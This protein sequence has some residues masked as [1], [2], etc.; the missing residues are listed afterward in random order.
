M[1]LLQL[2]RLSL[3]T[4]ANSTRDLSAQ[5]QLKSAFFDVAFEVES[6]GVRFLCSSHALYSVFAPF[7][8]AVFQELVPLVQQHFKLQL[9][10]WS[11][12]MLPLSELVALQEIGRIATPQQLQ[13]ID[14][15]MRRLEN[16]G[17]DPVAIQEALQ[18]SASV[19]ISPVVTPASAVAAAPVKAVTTAPA[20]A[21]TTA[22]AVVTVSSESVT[23]EADSL[24]QNI[25]SS[26]IV[27][28]PEVIT[29]N[30]AN[31]DDTSDAAMVVAVD[32]PSERAA[33]SQAPVPAVDADAATKAEV[34]T[35]AESAVSLEAAAADED[36]VTVADTV[37][38]LAQDHI[39][40]KA[41][42]LETSSSEPIEP[43]RIETEQT[44][45]REESARQQNLHK[46]LVSIGSACSV[47]G[48]SV[49]VHSAFVPSVYDRST[50][51]LGALA[52]DQL[53][54]LDPQCLIAP[55]F[56]CSLVAGFVEQTLN[57][58]AFAGELELESSAGAYEYMACPYSSFIVLGQFMVESS[59]RWGR[60]LKFSP[61][62]ESFTAE[63]L[64]LS[65]QQ[66]NST[67]LGQGQI[68]AHFASESGHILRA[69]NAEAVGVGMAL[70][71]TRFPTR[72]VMHDA[73][74]QSRL[75]AFASLEQ[76]GYITLAL[77]F[78][79]EQDDQSSVKR[80]SVLVSNRASA[81]ASAS[82]CLLHNS[83]FL[84]AAT[85]ALSPEDLY[86]VPSAYTHYYAEPQAVTFE[87]GT[88]QGYT[89][90]AGTVVPFENREQLIA[91]SV[92]AAVI[93]VAERQ[94][95]YQRVAPASASV[96]SV[97]E[98]EAI[99]AR[100]EAEALAYIGVD[101]QDA[102]LQ[103]VM[104][105]S[106]QSHKI[107]DTTS[108]DAV[109]SAVV[110]EQTARA[111]Q[112]AKPD[113]STS[114]SK[115]DSMILGFM[116]QE[117]Q[118]V[119]QAKTTEEEPSVPNASFIGA[120][121]A[122]A[123][124][125]AVPVY[126]NSN[127]P[128][129]NV[130]FAG[131]FRLAQESLFLA[132]KDYANASLSERDNH[133]WKKDF[134]NEEQTSHTV[135]ELIYQS[136]VIIKP[137]GL[138]ARSLKTLVSAMSHLKPDNTVGVM[139]DRVEPARS[140]S[141]ES[142]QNKEFSSE[143]FGV[144]S[145]EDRATVDAHASSVVKEPPVSAPALSTQPNIP[146]TVADSGPVAET[147][148]PVETGLV[149]DNAV[150]AQAS[151]A[152]PV[153][154]SA[155]SDGVEV[156]QDQKQVST[157]VQVADAQRSDE[158]MP[159]TSAVAHSAAEVQHE[160][161][162]P[163]AVKQTDV[164]AVAATTEP[165][166]NDALQ[167]CCSE[168]VADAPSLQAVDA[169]VAGNHVEVG[170]ES[171][172]SEASSQK[173][174]SERVADT[175]AQTVDVAVAGQKQKETEA[176]TSSSVQKCCSDLGSAK[177]DV[178]ANVAVAVA[179]G[180]EKPMAQDSQM[181]LA[182]KCCSDRSPVD[183]VATNV[184]VAVAGE[185]QT[186]V[187][188]VDNCSER[189]VAVAATTEVEGT[190]QTAM[191]KCCSE[192][193]ADAPSLQAVD[194]A[195]AGNHVEVDA[196]SHDSEASSQKC[197]SERVADTAALQTVDVAV[198][199]NH[200]EVGA[201]SHD[202]EASS[203][204]CCSERVDAATTVQ[205]VD[206]V[207]AGQK[208]KETEAVTSSS[209]QKCCSDLGSVPEVADDHVAVAV[210]GGLEKP[211][212]TDS[213][214]ALAQKCCSDLSSVESNVAANVAVAVAGGL[215]KPM[216]QDSQVALVQTCCSDRSC[217][218]SGVT[219]NVAVAVAGLQQE[220]VTNSSSVENCSERTV[221][222]ASTSA[223]AEQAAVL[224]APMPSE[225][226]VGSAGVAQ[227]PEAAVP[228]TTQP[229]A[230]QPHVSPVQVETAPVHMNVAGGGDRAQGL[231]Q[232]NGV[233][234]DTLVA[235]YPTAGAG[236]PVAAPADQASAV[237]ALEQ[238]LPNAQLD[239]VRQGAQRA[240]QSLAAAVAP[241][242]ANSLPRAGSP[243]VQ[244]MPAE[245]NQAMS[246][247]FGET[248]KPVAE[249]QGAPVMENGSGVD[250]L[251][252]ARM[253]SVRALDMAIP[254]LQQLAQSTRHGAAL[255][256]AHAHGMSHN[257]AAQAGCGVAPNQSQGF[258]QGQA[259]SQGQ[260]YGQ[261]QA[262]GQGQ[263][264][265]QGQSFGAGADQMVMPVQGETNSWQSFNPEFA[266]SQAQSPAQFGAESFTSTQGGADRFAVSPEQN[267]VFAQR[268]PFMS[269]G[270]AV[271]NSGAFESSNM[272]PMAP[273][274]QAQLHLQ[275]EFGAP[276]SFGNDQNF[277][278]TQ[279][280]G[281]VPSMGERAQFGA[282]SATS[283]QG[284]GY[285]SAPN[286]GGLNE[287]SGVVV[288]NVAAAQFNAS[289]PATAA[290]EPAATP[291]AM[292]Q[293]AAFDRAAAF[294]GNNS[295]AQP[296]AQDGFG[297]QGQQYQQ[298]PQAQFGPQAPMGQQGPMGPQGPQGPQGF[299][300]GADVEMDPDLTPEEI[301]L[302]RAKAEKAAKCKVRALAAAKAQ[303]LANNI[304]SPP[305]DFVTPLPTKEETLVPLNG[306]YVI[307]TP[308]RRAR[309]PNLGYEQPMSAPHA[310]N[311]A[312]GNAPV[313]AGRALVPTA[314]VGRELLPS[315]AQGW[316]SGYGNGGYSGGNNGGF[317]GAA[318]GM[319][320]EDLQAG[321]GAD[322]HAAKRLKTVW[323][324]G[325]PQQVEVWEELDLPRSAYN[326]PRTGRSLN[327]KPIDPS[328]V[329]AKCKHLTLMPD[330]TFERFIC[331]PQEN[332][333]GMVQALR[334][335]ALS[336]GAPSHNPIFLHGISGAG[337]SHLV[338]GLIH[339]LMLV[340]PKLKIGYF[341][342]SDFVK[343]YV[344]QVSNMQQVHYSP[345]QVYF[346]Q[347]FTNY[348]V[349]VMEDI[350]HLAR[351]NKSR[352]AFADIVAQILDMPGKMLVC[353][354]DRNT[355]RLFGMNFEQSLISRMCSG[356]TF[357][358]PAPERNVRWEV[359]KRFMEER[360]YKVSDGGANCICATIGTDIREILGVLKTVCATPLRV[361]ELG[362]ADFT[363][364]VNRLD[365]FKKVAGP[366]LTLGLIQK[367][368]AQYFGISVEEMLSPT[369]KRKV[370]LARAFAM[371]LARERL[372]L[373]LHDIGVAFN[374]DHS[375]VY[376][377][378]ER[379]RE[380]CRSNTE[381]QTTYLTF[382]SQFLP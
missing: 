11:I 139:S 189:T 374:K 232:A 44:A 119:V 207:V 218:E 358:V 299:G 261:A 92:V 77:D 82:A 48:A 41:T 381:L 61:T 357:E 32:E 336:P 184:A 86:N 136:E 162:E 155:T 137:V 277:G 275:T 42:E 239:A 157:P 99:N 144:E 134:I 193:V 118:G 243:V 249:L 63:L 183:G 87:H 201:E 54:S 210:A 151:A 331:G 145:D 263:V 211:M 203:Q 244:V 354:S 78:A 181:A 38:V 4:V 16:R 287:P 96:V 68:K 152:N 188:A 130:H 199:G 34:D 274:G 116:H 368:V 98:Q 285:M 153:A 322:G 235:P 269:A 376:E 12:H 36:T 320:Y 366:K 28:E 18:E 314:N 113:Q 289:R 329:F 85:L 227:M 349:L 213:Q 109:V 83:V 14:A 143:A 22:P 94:R 190:A 80:V 363:E 164:V 168:R 340:H 326:D 256:A 39:S 120:S 122:E 7:A 369:K 167:K 309:K 328:Q 30:A 216:A 191:Q 13:E 5:M 160:N 74:R 128:K 73:L 298:G 150:L 351:A 121:Q 117:Q 296:S 53:F 338:Q 138:T 59:P 52:S 175:T 64:A 196:E 81:S 88:I 35:K 233:V 132:A 222:V 131:G 259:Y 304:P 292:P 178:A 248:Q 194:A 254:E 3:F 148:Q 186:S 202:S 126:A 62:Q 305:V 236:A 265:G 66:V 129:Q 91:Q 21:V 380:R 360:G 217:V 264:Y 294:A 375:S 271:M 231:M 176:V 102:L 348:D 251:N 268:E 8:P 127:E 321:R 267:Q 25:A 306:G 110:M 2:W 105:P 163:T 112:A 215:E 283:G 72:A 111:A 339:E 303:A 124:K 270:D 343:Y 355:E 58:S 262:Y 280:F 57:A 316:R 310:A 125:L 347:S 230:M 24:S 206:V 1:T 31:T 379:L 364:L 97:Q 247:Q 325:Q 141:V 214:M 212:A 29:T 169:A 15:Q 372:E 20:E 356:L 359:V 318:E 377:A 293:E 161:V 173:C 317:N 288:N 101:P 252:A 291:E 382:Q 301:E 258:A 300:A 353:T 242:P 282:S 146:S 177:S 323:V 345:E 281:N 200:V 237:D 370:S 229:E 297:A 208:Q 26:E 103:D 165:V 333:Q 65:T 350:Q 371:L 159:T 308:P 171:H 335:A 45:M 106:E 179:G 60:D 204:K 140:A 253:N 174:C 17:L 319:S 182:Q 327:T 302:M 19:A 205:T 107:L 9:T 135:P 225:A 123:L 228:A 378:V 6:R 195:V 307:S 341:S 100:I 250:R 56:G 209:V 260:A 149:A 342:A 40:E 286:N 154:A 133:W 70:G 89:P 33:Q 170:A 192:R 346:T 257:A 43:V 312:A 223:V 365:N 67:R 313:S 166:E 10:S 324:N 180:L 344:S 84:D 220:A 27:E 69:A 198:A 255:A 373:S 79:C 156:V 75:A 245:H 315:A 185:D 95:E 224:T 332:I 367:S 187:G 278:N 279:S 284:D 272:Q 290:V 172:D 234:Q 114:K 47:I 226:Q 46:G 104:L 115:L 108:H 219:A 142:A 55:D 197:C 49:E 241:L 362:F 334:D 273:T 337:K 90:S 37:E 276:A 147:L 93:D 238:M 71:G 266:Q 50:Q 23:E 76:L 361:D 295:F 352:L 158:H 240:D 311:M 246:A 51:D 221:S 330:M